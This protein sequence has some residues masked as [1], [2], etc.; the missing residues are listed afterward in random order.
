MGKQPGVMF[1]FDLR[2]CLERFT[3]EEQGTLFRAI[4]DYGQLGIV[5]A[6]TGSLGVA[7]DFIQ[8]RLDRDRERYEQLVQQRIQ[9][10]QNRWSK[11]PAQQSDASAC[12]RMPTTT[13]R[14]NSNTAP[15]QDST[16][17][18]AAAAAV[19]A[20]GSVENFTWPKHLSWGGAPP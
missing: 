3:L 20:C 7:W 9:A 18:A 17:P 5:P 6:F 4:L 14:T 12:E 2:P 15:T 19:E 1:Y 10:A 11:E 13:T 16:A 8:P